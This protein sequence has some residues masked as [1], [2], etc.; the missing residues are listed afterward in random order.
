MISDNLQLFEVHFKPESPSKYPPI[1]FVP[2][3]G[4]FIDSW[5]I[6]LKEMTKFFEIFYIE[7]REKRSAEHSP[8]QSIS[9]EEIGSDLA[10]IVKIKDLEKSKFIVLGSSMGATAIIDSML[11]SSIKPS[12]SVLIGPNLEYRIPKIWIFI[13]KLLPASSYKLIKPMAKLYMKKKYIDMNSDP[14]QFTKYSFV[15]DNIHFERARRAALSFKDYSLKNTILNIDQK[16]LILSGR[17]DILHNYEDAHDLT[18]KMKN[19]KL[20]DMETN[21]RT[22][23]EELVDVLRDYLDKIKLFK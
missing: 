20:I 7:T 19:A 10:R 4:S 12:L 3:W 6:V 1:I 11:K 22:H 13:I 5:K 21:K 2:G 8:E 17:K 23:S 14:E 15:L 16:I 18:K 9:I